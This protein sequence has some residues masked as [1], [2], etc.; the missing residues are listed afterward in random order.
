MKRFFVFFIVII[1]MV[2][3]IP[4]LDCYSFAEKYKG[5]YYFYTTQN[6]NSAI[7]KTLQN[8]NGYVISCDIDKSKIVKKLLNSSMLFGESFC[9]CGDDKDVIK[10]LQ[11]LDITYKTK[12]DLDI[13]AYSPK[14]NYSLILNNKIYNV[15]ISKNNDIINVGFPAILGSF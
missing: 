7:T 1:A 4:L 5:T 8:G 14:I 15:Q 9:F 6:Y 10:L 11:K 3:S 13:V 2:C 12:N